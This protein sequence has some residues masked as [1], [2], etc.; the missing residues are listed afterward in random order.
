MK[1]P[2]QTN[3]TANSSTV[4]MGKKASIDQDLLDL[5]SMTLNGGIADIPEEAET[6][7]NYFQ[8]S[9]NVKKKS[10]ID[11][12]KYNRIRLDKTRKSAVATPNLPDKIV[13]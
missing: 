2:S 9:G 13:D 1:K 12:Q 5:E 8:N 6:A 4:K 11:F 3:K 7:R 10:A